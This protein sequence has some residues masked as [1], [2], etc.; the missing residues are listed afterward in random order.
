MTREA[1]DCERYREHIALHVEGDLDDADARRLER[2]LAACAPCRA[3]ADEMAASQQALRRQLAPPLDAATL[4]RVRAGVLAEIGRR[5]HAGPARWLALAATLLAAVALWRFWE[6]RPAEPPAA[7]PPV[8]T[9]APPDAEAAP[10]PP[11]VMAAAPSLPP[12]RD[13]EPS[14]PPPAAAVGPPE[15]KPLVIKLTSSDPDLVIYWLVDPAENKEKEH[16]TA[17]VL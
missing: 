1:V 7:E 9:P 16:E 14:P 11:A 8:V 15:R 12:P 13:R 6:P 3:W 17:T 2:H 10:E 5:R 4:A